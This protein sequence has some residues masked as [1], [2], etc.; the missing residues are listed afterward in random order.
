MKLIIK[1]VLILGLVASCNDNE[2]TVVSP[3]VD[4]GVSRNIKVMTFNIFGG[5]PR[6]ADRN[7]I[8]DY[9]LDN[10]IKT[11]KDSN[12]DIIGLNEI[13]V[14]QKAATNYDD[15]PK[16]IAEA[17]GYYYDFYGLEVSGKYG[18]ALLSKYPILDIKHVEYEIQG[19]HLKGLIEAKIQ[20]PD[21]DIWVYVTHLESGDALVRHYEIKEIKRRAAKL[22]DVPMLV[23]G[24]FNFTPDS[25]NHT[26]LTDAESVFIDPLGKSL[27]PNTFKLS[28]P[29]R[30][31][32]IMANKYFHF[33]NTPWSDT[34]DRTS[35]HF[36]VWANVC[37]YLN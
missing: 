33:V 3:N 34:E 26:L 29:K 23:L 30:I 27:D 36:P 11:I 14:N 6:G 37:F 18:V 22:G 17:L 1:L 35:D 2:E 16:L 13:G 21:G 9:G 31:D 12:P 24:D 28:D 15:Q 20:H 10:T 8:N 4:G 5:F 7:D 25:D 19:D 32:Y